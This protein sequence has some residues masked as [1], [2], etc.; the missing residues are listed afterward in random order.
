MPRNVCTVYRLKLSSCCSEFY[1]AIFIHKKGLKYWSNLALRQNIE[2]NVSIIRGQRGTKFWFFGPLTYSYL[3]IKS[4]LLGAVALSMTLYWTMN[5]SGKLLK[6]TEM[7]TSYL[8]LLSVQVMDI[9]VLGTLSGS[10]SGPF[11]ISILSE[12]NGNII[13]I[14]ILL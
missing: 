14:H 2:L 5:F 11:I 4:Q 12:F 10:A 7:Y 9:C 3:C 1:W 8:K 13:E 6:T